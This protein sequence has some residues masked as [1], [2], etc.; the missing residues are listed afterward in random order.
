VRLGY[1]LGNVEAQ[2]ETLLVRLYIAALKGREEERHGLSGNGRSPVAHADRK[3]LAQHCHRNSQFNCEMAHRQE[4]YSLVVLSEWSPSLGL[5]RRTL[6]S[7]K[8]LRHEVGLTALLRAVRFRFGRIVMR[9]F[10][11]TATVMCASLILES[12]LSG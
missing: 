1:F 7:R 9:G 12:T 6:R 2:S 5:A 4:S 10:N 8:R 11:R 3:T